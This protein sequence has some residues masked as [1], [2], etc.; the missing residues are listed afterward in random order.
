MGRGEVLQ[1]VDEEVAVVG[2]HGAPQLAV[3][4][5]RLER[6]EDLLVEV[7]HAPAAQRV[8]VRLEG[9]GQAGDVVEAVLDLLR[10]AQPEA[11]RATGRRGRARSDRC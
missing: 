3:V 5:Q 2:L 11:D 1:L 9:G 4:Q 6:A 8:A 10:V 7:D